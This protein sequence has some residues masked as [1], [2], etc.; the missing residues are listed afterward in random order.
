[1]QIKIRNVYFAI[2]YSI[3]S[4]HP[5]SLHF[6]NLCTVSLSI[7]HSESLVFADN[8]SSLF[9]IAPPSIVNDAGIK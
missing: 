1:M 6:I 3:V 7:R 5:D 2:H 4:S 8:H 9:L